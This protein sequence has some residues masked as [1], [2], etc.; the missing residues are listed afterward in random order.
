MNKG[1]QSTLFLTDTS[2]ELELVPAFLYS[3]YLTLYKMDTSLRRTF[4][5]GPKGVRL[6]ES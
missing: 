3:L 1:I 5:A 6:R 2:V 4:I